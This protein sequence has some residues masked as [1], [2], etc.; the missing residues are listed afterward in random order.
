MSI[1]LSVCLLA[2]LGR[3]VWVGR[4]DEEKG[5]AWRIILEKQI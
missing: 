2:E 5:K 1:Y 3:A 4:E